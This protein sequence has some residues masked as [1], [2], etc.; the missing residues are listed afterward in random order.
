[1]K[2][3]KK[4]LVGC[5]THKTKEY[6]LKEYAEAVKNLETDDSFEYDILLVDNTAG[7]QY[8]Q[9]I[10]EHGLPAVKG[11]WR[12]TARERIMMSRNVLRD[13]VL[14]EGYDYFF[15]LEQDVIPERDVL[16]RMMGVMNKKGRAIKILTSVVYNNMPYGEGKKWVPMLFAQHPV[17][18]EGLW[19]V[20][21]ESI[22]QPELK[23]VKAGHLACTLVHKEVLDLVKFRL[24][25]TTQDYM[26]FAKD[27]LDY[28]FMT[29]V[30]TG[31]R[32][33]HLVRE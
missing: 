33:K 6:C 31:I 28:G 21:E 23:R 14:K 32:P 19:Y 25:G 16:K 1:M 8:L 29:I 26:A 20:S 24:I 12:P 10:R 11:P 2:K 15:S 3:K 17:D 4:V 5:P 7:N 30:D 18:P 9:K 27:V 22:K 13:K